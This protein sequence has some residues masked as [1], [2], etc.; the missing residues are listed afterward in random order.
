MTA[1]NGVVPRTRRT[2]VLPPKIEDA[3]QRSNTRRGDNKTS[4]LDYASGYEDGYR[5]ALEEIARTA[6]RLQKELDKP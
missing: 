2:W 6:T 3:F 1:P 4:R 5:D